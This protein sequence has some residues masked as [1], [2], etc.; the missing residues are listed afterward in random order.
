MKTLVTTCLTLALALA[1]PCAKAQS[2]PKASAGSEK[3]LAGAV[4][5]LCGKKVALL[6][7]GPTHGDGSTEQFKAALVDRLIRQCGFTVIVFEA[8]HYEFLNLER[9][10]KS[11]ERLGES[12][13]AAAVGGL[14][15]FDVEFQPLL[16]VLTDG[17]NA[18][19]LHLGGL[20]DQL[21]VIG[22]DFANKQLGE[23]LTAGMAPDRRSACREAIRH[24]IY[25]DYP[26]ER[27]YSATDKDALLL[28]LTQAGQPET[29]CKSRCCAAS[30][31]GS[32]GICL[33][34]PKCTAN[35]IA[36]CSRISGG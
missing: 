14:W 29:P 25:Q 8:S 23:D 18:G 27:P 28:C 13:V 20:D 9:A 26:R 24:R 11:G 22:Q 16:P 4:R 34:T 6:G 15:R 19:T 36:R 2:S 10:R 17:F 30:T 1:S 35:A 33:A 3:A 7:E 31:V 32:D 12:Q 5:D 21:G